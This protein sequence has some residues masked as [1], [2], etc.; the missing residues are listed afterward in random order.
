MQINNNTSIYFSHRDSLCV[1]NPKNQEA[2]SYGAILE[3]SIQEEMQDKDSFVSQIYLT[4]LNTSLLEGEKL[5]DT[6]GFSNMRKVLEMRDKETD[7]NKIQNLLSENIAFLENKTNAE[8]RLDELGNLNPLPQHIFEAE[9]SKAIDIL[10][11][12]LQDIKA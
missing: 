9:K 6:L 11:G 7:S 12:I 1:E 3:E 2:K 8:Y 10:S 5:Y 4:N